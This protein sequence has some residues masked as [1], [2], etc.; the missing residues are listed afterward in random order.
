MNQICYVCGEPPGKEG[1]VYVGQGL[2]RHKIKCRPGSKN[3]A[4]WIQTRRKI[5]EQE[6][7][8]KFQDTLR[9]MAKESEVIVERTP[10]P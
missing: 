4:I 8:H 9:D 5:R 6:R 7:E 2:S 3:W 10:P 1:F